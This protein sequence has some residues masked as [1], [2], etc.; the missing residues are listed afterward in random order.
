[1][2]LLIIIVFVIILLPCKVVH[3]IVALVLKTIQG[4][5]ILIENVG[6]KNMGFC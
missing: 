5:I 2:D 1:M 3:S 4:Q 6:T